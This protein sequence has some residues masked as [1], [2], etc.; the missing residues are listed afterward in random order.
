MGLLI[1]TGID[2]VGF[3]ATDVSASIGFRTMLREKLARVKVFLDF[4][5]GKNPKYLGS[6]IIIPS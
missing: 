2:A 6:R 5:F 3:N 4:W 1:L